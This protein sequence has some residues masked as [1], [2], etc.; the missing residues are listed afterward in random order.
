MFKFPQVIHNRACGEKNFLLQLW[1]PIHRKVSWVL[2][3]HIN[4]AEDEVIE[5]EVVDLGDEVD[6]SDDMDIEDDDLIV[7]EGG[8][9]EASSREME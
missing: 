5:D 1:E 7:G 8:E 4:M 2:N 6:F 9:A 3:L